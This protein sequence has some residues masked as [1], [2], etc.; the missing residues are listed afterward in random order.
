MYMRDIVSTLHFNQEV[1]WD[2]K[3]YDVLLKGFDNF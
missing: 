2:P 1:E 3:F